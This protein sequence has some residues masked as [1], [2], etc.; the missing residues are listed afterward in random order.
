[1]RRDVRILGWVYQNIRG[2]LR[3][4]SIELGDPPVRWTLVQMPNGTGKTTTMSLFRA[5]LTGEALSVQRVRDL[6][7][8][9]DAASGLFELRISVD[10][11]PYRLQLRLDYRAGTASY[12]TARSEVRGGGLEEGSLLPADLSK[13]LTREFVRLFVFDGELA[14]EIR[15]V[16]KERAAEAIRTLYRLDKLDDVSRQV[17]RL[18][19]E[20]QQKAASVSTAT[21]RK[22]VTRWSNAVASATARKAELHKFIRANQARRR[23]LEEQAKELRTQIIGHVEQDGTLKRRKEEL[24]AARV[25]IDVAIVQATADGLAV[26]RSPGK[27]HP[28][29]FDRLHALGGK[30]NQLKLPKTISEEFFRELAEQERCV[31]GRPLGHTERQA[32]LD[33]AK[34]YLAEDQIAV[35]NAMKQALRNAVND[36]SDYTA[37]TATLRQKLKELQRNKTANDQLE[38]E[39]IE[40]GDAEVEVLR[41]RERQV[42]EESRQVEEAL[43]RLTTKDPTRHRQLGL[44]HD[45]NLPLCDAELRRCREKLATATDTRRFMLQAEFVRSIIDRVGATALELLRERVRLATNEKLAHFAP[46]EALQVGRIAGSLELGSPG[47]ALKSDVSEGQSLSV[48]YAFLTSLLTDAPY[49]LPFIIDSPA[50]SLDT[51]MRREVGQLI[52]ELFGQMIM[53]VISSEKDGFAEAFYGRE[54]VRYLTL[55]RE[56]ETITATR[57]GLAE[58]KAFHS[59]EVA[60]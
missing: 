39:R 23:V 53:F 59:E 26:L 1:M 56:S 16:G 38:L 34:A 4:V 32:V 49:Q 9:D 6:R 13:L 55:W 48:A 60:G 3:D 35:I 33:G 45:T 52:P 40:A 28:R 22:G 42:L 18:V 46:S 8:S 2:G 24:A 31:C 17:S 36:G 57:A 58:F 5:V 51:R 43:E 25:D 21:E 19:D 54:G 7:C 41:N 11:K 30:L 10:G 14:K 50:V 27:L 29:I 47:N 20:K 12:W 15:M 44:D 37:L